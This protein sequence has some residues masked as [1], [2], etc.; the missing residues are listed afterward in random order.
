M[1]VVSEK[2]I[3]ADRA[4]VRVIEAILNMTEHNPVT[5]SDILGISLKKLVLKT[6]FTTD[7]V[8]MLVNL[9]SSLSIN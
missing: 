3:S 6:G 7:E 2:V 8:S 1:D 5:L 4:A 9:G